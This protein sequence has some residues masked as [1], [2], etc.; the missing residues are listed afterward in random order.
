MFCINAFCIA[1]PFNFLI[2]HVLSSG[3]PDHWTANL[4]ARTVKKG[5]VFANRVKAELKTY[6]GRSAHKHGEDDNIIM[7]QF[8]GSIVYILVAIGI[9]LVELC[10]GESR[11]KRRITHL[12]ARVKFAAASSIRW[13]KWKT[14]K[15]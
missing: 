10:V 15:K 4:H 2:R 8:K 5:K 9:F 1:E 7:L 3:I 13:V 6:A 12:A 14:L 11:I